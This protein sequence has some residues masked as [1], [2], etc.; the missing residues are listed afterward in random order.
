MLAVAP[1]ALM[2][3]VDELTVTAGVEAATVIDRLAEAVAGTLSE[4]ATCTVKLLTPGCVGVPVMAPVLAF[5][6]RPAGR[7]PLAT[8]QVKGAIPFCSVRVCE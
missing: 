6:V 4:S 3:K 7:L 5:K 1:G 8:L 2:F